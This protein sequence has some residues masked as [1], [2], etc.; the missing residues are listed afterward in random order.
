MT[1]ENISGIVQFGLEY[2]RTRVEVA[3][4]N[5]AIANVPMAPGTQANVQSV[6]VRGAFASAFPQID[7]QEKQGSEARKVYD[8]AHPL[9]DGSGMVSYPKI[10]PAIEMATL[11]AA[12][13]AY[14]ADVRSYNTLR[15][16][17]LKAF[18]IGK[19]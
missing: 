6:G 3:A 16:M 18:E 19:S 17:A 8:P 11:V 13:R 14:E 5:L 7:I 9:A 15:A 12:T 2:E 1:V 4:R 10:D